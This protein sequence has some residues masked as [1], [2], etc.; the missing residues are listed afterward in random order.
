MQSIHFGSIRLQVSDKAIEDRRFLQ[1]GEH[2]D[3]LSIHQRIAGGKLFGQ[4]TLEAR[5]LI[6]G[7]LAA[8][9][10]NLDHAQHVEKIPVA[11]KGAHRAADLF[12]QRERVLSARMSD[13]QGQAALDQEPVVLGL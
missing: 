8:H 2:A 7:Q 3:Q 6:R 4:L 9:E 1:V 11:H 12:Q 10:R 5:N 13:H